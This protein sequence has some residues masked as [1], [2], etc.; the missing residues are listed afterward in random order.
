[1]L[2]L[3]PHCPPIK[4][5]LYEATKIGMQHKGKKQAHHKNTINITVSEMGHAVV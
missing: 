2:S 3:P 5:T 4:T 1:M